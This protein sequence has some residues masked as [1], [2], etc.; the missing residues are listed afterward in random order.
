MGWQARESPLGAMIYLYSEA[1][2][3]LLTD[4]ERALLHW[5]PAENTAYGDKAA[6]ELAGSRHPLP[7]ARLRGG[8]PYGEPCGLCGFAPPPRYSSNDTV[9]EWIRRFA[10]AG[11]YQPPLYVDAALLLDP[12]PAAFTVGDPR[13]YVSLVLQPAR[14]AQLGALGGKRRLRAI[15]GWDLG[16]VP[17]AL[18]EP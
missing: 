12:P 2:L 5:R 14:W 11:G 3:A 10:A 17:P 7:L 1:F 16:V 15:Q 18:V 6:F 13:E 9:P 8:S 4:E